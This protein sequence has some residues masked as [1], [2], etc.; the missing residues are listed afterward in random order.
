MTVQAV[1]SQEITV[2]PED[3]DALGHVNNRV[4]MD[5]LEAVATA[6]SAAN[7]WDRKAYFDAGFVWVIREHWIE[8]LRPCFAGEKLVMST[9]VSA[10][11][12]GLCLRRYA[13]HRAGKLVLTAATE[14]ALID[15]KSGRLI[16]ECPGELKSAF[17]LVPDGR[18][19]EFVKGPVRAPHYAPVALAVRP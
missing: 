15:I 13:L 3:I 9:W 18:I 11:A 2:V 10:V 6:A 14:W 1:F 7:G 19:G 17:P 5:W 12:G 16:A 4:Y 8:Y